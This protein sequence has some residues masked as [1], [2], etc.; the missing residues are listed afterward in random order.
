MI[1]HLH[2]KS[3]PCEDC[4]AR[5]II[6]R[7]FPLLVRVHPEVGSPAVITFKP[8]IFEHLYHLWEKPRE[9]D[10]P[11]ALREECESR[12]MY[13]EYLRDSTIWRAP[14]KRWV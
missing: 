5:A 4:G 10:T 12:G 11:Q 1:C 14:S 2:Y 7:M 6:K 3:T 9:I 8:A 13:S